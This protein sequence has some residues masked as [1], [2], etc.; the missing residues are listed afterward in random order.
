M[1]RTWAQDND[2][3]FLFLY[4]DT[5]FWNSTPEKNCQNLTNLTRWNKRDKVWSS[6][7]SLFKWRFRNRGRRCCLSSLFNA[8]QLP[9]AKAINLF[10]LLQEDFIHWFTPREGIVDSFVVKVKCTEMIWGKERSSPM[11]TF[12]CSYKWIKLRCVLRSGSWFIML[13]FFQGNVFLLFSSEFC[14]ATICNS[15]DAKSLADAAGELGTGVTKCLT[16]IPRARIWLRGHEGKRNNCFSKIQLVGQK[17]RDK[18]T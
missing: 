1:F 12:F 2:F 8:N 13:L 4:F 7:T 15:T 10:F 14:C 17:Y 5:V 18:T 6:A 11:P 3:L 9:P 16:I